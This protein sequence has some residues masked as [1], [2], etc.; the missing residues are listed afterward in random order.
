MGKLRGEP[1]NH[2]D[3][4]PRELEASAEEEEVEP[5]AEH[6]DLVEGVLDG[7]HAEEADGQAELHQDAGDEEANPGGAQGHVLQEH[8]PAQEPKLSGRE[9]GDNK[10]G[11]Y[12]SA[13]L[14]K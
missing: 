8:L 11:S 9:E 4:G 1:I 12:S 2:D 7:V 14:K 10:R 3:H 5:V 6:D 13:Q